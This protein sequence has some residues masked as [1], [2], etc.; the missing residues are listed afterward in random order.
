[1]RTVRRPIVRRPEPHRGGQR[2]VHE[3]VGE[4]GHSADSYLACLFCG[5]EPKPL[6]GAEWPITHSD[7]GAEPTP[8]LRTE[9]VRPRDRGVPVRELWPH[10][11]APSR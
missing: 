9:L 11:R 3:Q 7:A 6:A 10:R 5:R 2:L 8:V 1:M 4:R